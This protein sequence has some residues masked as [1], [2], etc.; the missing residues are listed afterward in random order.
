MI[1]KNI[2]Y[3]R[4]LNIIAIGSLLLLSGCD[5]KSKFCGGQGSSCKKLAD[6]IEYPTDG[7]TV[8]VSM[9]GKPL[10]TQKSL[11]IEKNDLLEANP[12]LKSMVMYM[13]P[14]ALDRNI[15]EGLMSQALV[16]RYIKEMKID[17]RADYQQD[18]KRML[19]SV[20]Q[21]LDTKYFTQ[22]FPISVTDAD[23]QEFYEKNKD[24]MPHF[25]LSRGG[26]KAM[27]ISFEKEQEAK[28]F[29][30]KVKTNKNDIA[31]AAQGTDLAK[32]VT[33]FKL[34]SDQSIGIDNELKN[35]ILAMK[36]PSASIIKVN[37]KTFWVVVAHG[38]EENKYRPFDQIKGDIRQL[39]E[40]EKRVESFDQEIAKL[41]E[42]YKIEFN[43]E[44][45][46]EQKEELMPNME[47]EGTPDMTGQGEQDAAPVNQAPRAA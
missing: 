33:D 32:K 2:A 41:K 25:L 18:L 5:W 11:E 14:E 40:K 20:Q 30:N 21:M 27:G 12:Q 1:T 34:V 31:K 8:L 10:I 47:Q 39:L 19:R 42:K 13:D 44:F 43:A 23:L 26:I 7:S 46:K 6:A 38:K 17:E 22:E 9:E 37:D 45:F 35:K 15:T 16:T 36:A 28:D 29:L 24:I 4:G 3:V